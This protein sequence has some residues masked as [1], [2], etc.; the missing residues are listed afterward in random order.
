MRKQTREVRM[1]A[2][3][4][5]S[6]TRMRLTV[7]VASAIAA[8]AISAIPSLATAASPADKVSSAASLRQAARQNPNTGTRSAAARRAMRRGYLVPNQ[9]RY[10][11]QKAR[12][13][14]EV[15][16][17]RVASAPAGGP[18]APVQVR[19]WAGINN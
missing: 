14:R 10:E 8:F 15:R 12:A 11:R 4:F 1:P 18:L 13:D 16:G 7:A 19:A 17:A 5:S 9:R 6:S 2:K 3:F